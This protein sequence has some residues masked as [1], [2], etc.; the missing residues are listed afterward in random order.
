MIQVWPVIF[1]SFFLFFFCCSYEE[2]SQSGDQFPLVMAFTA[3]SPSILAVD[4]AVRSI[5][6]CNI[7]R[8]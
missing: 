1:S 7:I 6:N 4:P 3:A 8:K 2:E 5:R